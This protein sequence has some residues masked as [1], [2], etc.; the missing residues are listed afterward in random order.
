MTEKSALQMSSISERL[1]C[2]ALAA[3]SPVEVDVREEMSIGEAV[4]TRP[5]PWPH[6]PASAPSADPWELLAAQHVHNPRG[7]NCAPH[8]N[9]A[10]GTLRGPADAFSA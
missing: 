2:R 5:R 3:E 9:E 6:I 1:S 10:R 4:P 7:A 8:G